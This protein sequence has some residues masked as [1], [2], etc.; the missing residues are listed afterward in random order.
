MNTGSRTAWG[1]F[2]TIHRF[3]N[4]S[5]PTATTGSVESLTKSW[6][7]PGRLGFAGRLWVRRGRSHSKVNPFHYRAMSAQQ[8]TIMMMPV[9]HAEH[10]VLAEGYRDKNGHEASRPLRQVV[11]RT[12]TGDVA[13]VPFPRAWGA[14]QLR[15]A[16]QARQLEGVVPF[17]V[18]I[19]DGE[20]ADSESAQY[21]D[22]H[23]V[24]RAV[25]GPFREVTVYGGVGERTVSTVTVE[26]GINV[27]YMR[28]LAKVAFHYFLWSS[29]VLRGD[30]PVFAGVRD[31]ISA[32]AGN[33]RDF[34]D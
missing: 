1:A 28:A 13:S 32:G 21:F 31:L 27:T 12:A 33:Y 19:E 23:R 7:A 2:A 22:P 29:P 16:I 3:W 24:L 10:K 20:S 8:P 9:L 26:A 15:A 30:E 18:Y 14:D 34:V 4:V 5:A 11:V 25:F 17:E 6:H